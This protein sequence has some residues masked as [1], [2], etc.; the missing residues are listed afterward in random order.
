MQ[1]PHPSWPLPGLLAR[2]TAYL[3][4]TRPSLDRPACP[5]CHGALRR[6]QRRP[7]DRLLSY[8]VPVRRY[9]CRAIACDWAG[10]LRDS[11]FALAPGDERRHYEKR[12]DTR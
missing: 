11:R 1:Q 5:C 2:L 7:I 4:G 12:I 9:R 8:W 10:T 3:S 6:V